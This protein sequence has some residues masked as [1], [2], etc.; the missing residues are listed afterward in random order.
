MVNSIFNKDGRISFLPGPHIYMDRERRL[1]SVT[2][3]LNAVTQPF[4]RDGISAKMANHEAKN[5]RGSE[6]NPDEDTR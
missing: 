4:D 6:S 2:N 1:R 5:R 3:L